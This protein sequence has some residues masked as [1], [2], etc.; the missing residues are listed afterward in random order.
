MVEYV[1]DL[2]SV[3]KAHL[4][5]AAK[6]LS[7]AF[8]DDPLSNEVF[9]EESTRY[10][11][12][13]TYFLFRIN[14][15]IKYGEVYATSEEFDGVAIWLPGK[16]AHI[17]NWRGMLSGGIKLYSEIGRELMTK[18]NEINH[19][20]TSFRNSIIQPPYYQL[21][22]IG[23]IPEMQGKGFGNKL[24]KPMFERFDDKKIICF[25]ETQTEANIPLY[26][27]YGFRVLKEGKIPNTNLHHWGMKREPK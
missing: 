19:Y 10:N 27:K 15:G 26:Q 20:T 4:D 9:S 13:M 5:E 12:L 1:S 3:K 7:L 2:L 6:T 14:Y 17:S 11:N 22:P 23:V 25:L 8:M 18:F 24:L 21:S 16:R